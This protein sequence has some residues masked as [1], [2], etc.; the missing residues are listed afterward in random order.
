M[1]AA[2]G[3]G[4]GCG[5]PVRSQ[6]DEELKGRRAG[7]GPEARGPGRGSAARRPVCPLNSASVVPTL[8]CRTASKGM[9]VL[10]AVYDAS[11]NVCEPVWVCALVCLDEEAH[12]LYQTLMEPRTETSLSRA[13]FIERTR[14]C[15]RL[16]D[17]PHAEVCSVLP[18]GRTA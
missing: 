10:R 14:H 5:Q 11:E 16:G 18:R 8:G 3:P 9:E 17:G 12:G 15:S 2:R 4:R 1:R 6:L 7:P 13:C